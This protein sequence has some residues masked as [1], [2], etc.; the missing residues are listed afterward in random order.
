MKRFLLRGD[1][2][3]Y[4]QRRP[5]FADTVQDDF[6]PFERHSAEHPLGE[7]S[8]F[9]SDLSAKNVNLKNEENSSKNEKIGYNP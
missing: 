4:E 5:H 6:L 7:R 3:T 8:K 9:L 1:F 2:L